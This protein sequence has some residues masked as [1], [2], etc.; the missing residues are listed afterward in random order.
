MTFRAGDNNKTA[1]VVIRCTPDEKAKAE[2]LAN[3]AGLSLSAFFRKRA[4][5]A[6]VHSKADAAMINEL[7]KMGG[8]VKHIH[9]QTDGVNSKETAAVLVELTAAIK[10][11]VEI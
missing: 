7:R 5:G 2:A 3:E 4:L 11:I 10:R 8:L 9:N 1:L 6:P